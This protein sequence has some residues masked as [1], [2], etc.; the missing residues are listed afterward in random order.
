MKLPGLALATIASVFL[1]GFAGPPGLS[2]LDEFIFIEISSSGGAQVE[3][4][5]AYLF[6]GEQ[7]PL[8][9][10]R[11]TTPFVLQAKSNYVAAVFRKVSGS[12]QLSARLSTGTQTNKSSILSGTGDAIIFTTHPESAKAKPSYSIQAL[13]LQ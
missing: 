6:R 11:H 4:D 12:D 5:V 10:E 2:T 1:F 9:F 13:G 3:F 8:K 7:S